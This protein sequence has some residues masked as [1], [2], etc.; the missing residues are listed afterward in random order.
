M[1][2]H[3]FDTCP[4]PPR[5]VAAGW[6]CHITQGSFQA[7][8]VLSS[9]QYLLE[10]CLPFQPAPDLNQ[11]LLQEKG[12]VNPYSAFHLQVAWSPYP[13]GSDIPAR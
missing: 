8:T 10:P 3:T 4:L 1:R 12:P 6:P 13:M 9:W 2:L 5:P 7:P 11:L